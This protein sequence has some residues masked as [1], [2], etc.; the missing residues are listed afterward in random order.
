MT[1]ESGFTLIELM[2]TIAIVAI[3]AAVALPMFSEQMAR[4][5][6]S[7]AIST[8]TQLQL[9]QEHW[10]AN[11]ATYGTLAEVT[12]AAD[13]AAFNAA[14]P[15][16]DYSVSAASGTDVLVTATPKAGQQGDRCGNFMLRIDNDNNNAPAGTVDKTTSNGAE[17]CW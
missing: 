6:R 10:R 16:Y 5:R 11:H 8:L 4:G 15:H 12:G 3:L 2:V 17:R 14:H 1:R 13:D 7:D 9:R